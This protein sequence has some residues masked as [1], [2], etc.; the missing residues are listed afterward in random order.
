M[1]PQKETGASVSSHKH[2]VPLKP[3]YIRG[4]GEREENSP[5]KRQGALTRGQHAESQAKNHRSSQPEG[6]E[7]FC[8]EKAV[9]LLWRKQEQ[10]PVS[11]GA[12]TG[13]IKGDLPPWSH[14]T[15][16]W[17]AQTTLP[18][19]CLHPKAPHAQ[20]EP[21]NWVGKDVKDLPKSAGGLSTNPE[22]SKSSP[23]WP[24]TFLLSSSL[25]TLCQSLLT[26]PGKKFF[27]LP[28]KNT[29]RKARQSSLAD[30]VSLNQV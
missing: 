23:S 6:V 11:P 30:K 29:P 13:G 14:R 2:F 7:L 12:Q 9:H 3:L 19:S 26:L 5:E 27:L 21:Q 18:V 17:G 15:D 16:T 28:E 1:S 24:W 8:S 20:K 4:E 25:G 22:C 10:L